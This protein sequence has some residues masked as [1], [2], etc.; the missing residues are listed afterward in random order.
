VL[1]NVS[2]LPGNVT[3]S[4]LVNLPIGAGA[5]SKFAWPP[6]ANA[7][8]AALPVAASVAAPAVGAAL[9]VA[10]SVAAPKVGAAVSGFASSVAGSLAAAPA[11]TVAYWL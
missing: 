2:P 11:E 8:P 6:A 3:V 5:L 7:N 4:G 10:A 9:P 1:T